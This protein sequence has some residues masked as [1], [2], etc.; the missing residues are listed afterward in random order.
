MLIDSDYSLLIEAV[1]SSRK[2]ILQ[3]FG[4]DHASVLKDDNSPV[5]KTDLALNHYLISAIKTLY[6]GSAIVSEEN[7]Y[8][9]NVEA[10]SH[11]KVFIIDPLDGTK[12]FIKNS[13]EFSVNVAL[14]IEDKL[15]MGIIYSPIEDVLYY[16]YENKFFKLNYASTSNRKISQVVEQKGLSKEDKITVIATKNED[17]LN[18]IK[19][20]L[21]K[22]GYKIDFISFA[23]SLKFCYLAE[24][25]ADIYFRTARIKLWDVAAGFA[26]VSAVEFE[27]VDH[28]NNDLMKKI[29]NKEN[30]KNLCERNFEI[31]P[32]VVKKSKLVIDL[33]K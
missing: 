12:S 27:V 18:Q 26:I 1:I 17:E 11:S 2:I 15:V 13:P 31:D 24:G 28:H 30:I 14:K 3:N 29:L 22:T 4:I 32:F 5:T 6:P 33:D 21:S 10:I 20:L 25:M 9:D 16:A 23:S 7:V 19:K 8:E